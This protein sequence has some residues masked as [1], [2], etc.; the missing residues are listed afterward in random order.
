MN[1]YREILK[2]ATIYVVRLIVVRHFF[3]SMNI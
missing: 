1:L 2:T 3:L